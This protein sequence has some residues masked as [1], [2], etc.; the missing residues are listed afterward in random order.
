VLESA[1]RP[2]RTPRPPPQLG[3]ITIGLLFATATDELHREQRQRARAARR[4]RREAPAPPHG[5]GYRRLDRA[6]PAL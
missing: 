1:V 6:G 4:D 3:R 5:P 2:S